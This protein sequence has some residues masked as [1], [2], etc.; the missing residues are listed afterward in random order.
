MVGKILVTG[1]TGFIGSHLVEALLSEGYEVKCLVRR[2]SDYLRRL[3]AE[4]VRGDI[5]VRE[6]LRGICKDID[7]VYHLAALSGKYGTPREM[8]WKANVEGT[9]NLLEECVKSNV[10]H[11]IY[12]SSFTVTGPSKKGALINESF[13][14]NP[15]TAY[16]LTKAVAEQLVL[17]YYN[18][19][20]LPVTIIRPSNVYGPRDVRL[21]ELFKTICEGRFILIGRGKGVTHFVYISD[22]IQGFK[23]CLKRKGD[24][25]IF[26]IA[27][28]R[29]VT[30]REF[31][32]I[33]AKEYGRKPIRLSIPV[34]LA[35]LLANLMEV[36]AKLISVKPP[37]TNSRI[38]YLTGYW[39][40]DISK[41]REKLGYK[42][43][44]SLEEGVRRTLEWYI[45]NG[46][47]KPIARRDTSH[48]Y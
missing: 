10:E 26:N 20:G 9:K 13:P 21:L 23:L 39:A 15:L 3:G 16:E 4:V 48:A 28:D 44:I 43:K 2:T 33:V 38:R 32:E 37:L 6:T 31:A 46:Y 40:Y 36:S 25:E 8:L 24:G 35:K 18:D 45:K 22:L 14:Y 30:W 42:P 12:T 19:Y 41:A 1:A 17:K 47:L 27:G 34:W 5:T 29:P 11:F 7:V